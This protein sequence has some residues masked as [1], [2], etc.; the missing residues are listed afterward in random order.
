MNR[1]VPKEKGALNDTAPAQADL[2]T[3]PEGGRYIRSSS[4]YLWEL[5]NQGKIPVVKIGR[6]RF[7]R[8]TDLD[9]YI[10]AQTG[11]EA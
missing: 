3:Y 1:V 9:A 7:V 6:K 5:V 11:R 8:R 2:M 10:E 4:R